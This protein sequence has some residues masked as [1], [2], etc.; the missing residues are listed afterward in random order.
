MPRVYDRKPRAV[1]DHNPLKNLLNYQDVG[2][3]AAQA[4][5]KIRTGLAAAIY[6]MTGVDLS[7]WD[8]FLA[9]LNDGK[10]ID[11]PGLITAFQVLSDLVDNLVG[12]IKNAYVG[13]V[14]TIG[15]VVGDIWD[16]IS[17]LLGIGTDAGNG[18]TNANKG[19][20]EI[21]AQLAAGAIPGGV[22][23]SDGFSYAT[24]SAL[25]NPPYVKHEYG[26]GSGQYGPAHA[27]GGPSLL[28]WN[29][30]GSAADRTIL[31]ADTTH[32]LATDNGY[33]TATFYKKTG[34]SGAAT[35]L[36]G[37]DDGAAG[38]CVRVEVQKTA[39]EIQSVSSGNTYT[40]VGSPATI[41]TADG[42]VFEFWFGTISDPTLLWVVQNGNI[43][44]SP[45][46][47]TAH[48]IG[49]GNRCCGVGGKGKGLGGFSGQSPPAKINGITFADQDVA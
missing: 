7:S 47:D 14:D 17:G 40:A 28:Q 16:V 43:V 42:D 39:V 19:V 30:T 33:V 18:A 24:A 41:T 13:T 21:K 4:G 2:A 10:G 31:Y 32:P 11:L 44:I 3:Y 45:I 36:I 25:P 34:G 1:D 20:Q 26:A 48:T 49:S 22:Y 8:N 27:S 23:I 12:A 15:G 37:R 46:T 9:S 29:Q 6:E 38:T 35:Y 5:D